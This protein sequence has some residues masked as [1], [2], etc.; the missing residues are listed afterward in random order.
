MDIKNKEIIQILELSIQFGAFIPLKKNKY[1]ILQERGSDEI[2]EYRFVDNEIIRGNILM[3]NKY[4]KIIDCLE[5]CF[6][7]MFVNYKN[8]SILVLQ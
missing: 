2:G 8:E 3:K 6:D 7:I 4:I 5:D 1:I